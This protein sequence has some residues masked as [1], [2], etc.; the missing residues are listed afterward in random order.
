MQ[1]E[2]PKLLH[3]QNTYYIFKLAIV[4]AIFSFR[5]L[6]QGHKLLSC[7]MTWYCSIATVLLQ[8]TLSKEVHVIHEKTFW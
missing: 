4:Y 6:T 1:K 7:T 2:T 5:Q 3:M 8:I